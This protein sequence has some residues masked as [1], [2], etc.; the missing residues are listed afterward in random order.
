M[1]TLV[2]VAQLVYRASPVGYRPLG[3]EAAAINA[4][5]YAIERAAAG[6][7]TRLTVNGRVIAE[8]VPPETGGA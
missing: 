7:S 6:Q 1:A 4:V 2:D 3:D 8:I 5:A